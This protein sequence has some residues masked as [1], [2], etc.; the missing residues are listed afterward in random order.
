M[1]AVVIACQS[2]SGA[3]ASAA[4]CQFRGSFTD[5]VLVGDGVPAGAS[6]L[7]GASH[8]LCGLEVAQKREDLIA[9]G[10]RSL[11]DCRS[12]QTVAGRE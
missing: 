7:P 2:G 10:A 9:T 11:S 1:L 3:A 8:S 5:A 12:G 6:A 4:A